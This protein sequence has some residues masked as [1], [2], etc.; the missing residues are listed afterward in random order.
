MDVIKMM[1][2][3]LDLEMIFIRN[4]INFHK[5]RNLQRKV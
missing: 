4:N 1:L 5:K 2:V 3:K